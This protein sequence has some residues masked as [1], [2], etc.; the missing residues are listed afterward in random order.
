M[1]TAAIRPLTSRVF[2][3]DTSGPRVQQRSYRILTKNSG[4]VA[5]VG[6]RLRST[7][8]ATVKRFLIF[9]HR[10][11][12][13]VLCLVFL[14]WFPSGIGMMYW[15]FPS[16]SAADRL[17]RSPALRASAIQLSPSEAFAKSGLDQPGQIHL[18]TFDGRPVYRFRSGGGESVIYA[19]TGEEQIQVSR[20][21]MD[22][23]AASWARQPARA[24]I[25]EPIHDVDQWTVQT[26]LS[27]VEPLWKYSWS[28]GQQAYV[29]QA[30]GEIVQYTTR[31]SRWGAYVGAIPHWLYFTPLRTHGPEWSRV[32][33]WSSAKI[34]RA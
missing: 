13:V 10:W 9:V 16:V 2:I 25:V 15:D 8:A 23:I 1:T 33:I 14:L 29:S 34:G 18:S 7:I 30:S 22:R 3:T 19:D 4:N 32:V 27:D 6:R 24:A 17:E 5:G 31:G 11:L 12:G 20:E 28:D 21:M 26:R